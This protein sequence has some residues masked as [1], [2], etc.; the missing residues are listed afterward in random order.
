MKVLDVYAVY[1]PGCHCAFTDI[2]YRHERVYLAFREAVNHGVSASGQI[3]VLSSADRGRTF[4][5]HARIAAAG[6]DLRDPHFFTVDGRVGLMIPSWKVDSA[7]GGP[8]RTCHVAFST[9][10]LSWELPELS[11]LEG[12]TLWRPAAGPDGMVYAVGYTAGSAKGDY[13]AVLHRTR[14]G[15]TWEEVSVVHDEDGANETDIVFLADGEIVALVRCERN[16]CFPL[17][18]RSRPPYTEWRK[19]R[20]DRFLQGPLLVRDRKGGL[21]AVGRSAEPMDG[22]GKGTCMTRGF[23]LDPDTGKTAYLFT[24][25]SGG[26]TSYAGYAEIGEGTALLSYYSGHGYENGTYR[27][28]LEVQRTAVYVARLAVSED[29]RETGDADRKADKDAV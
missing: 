27:S 20:C 10:M 6:Y 23:S 11:E 24:L 26:D 22:G 15:T 7:G 12:W 25:P 2:L 16:P 28:G 8:V 19:V 14:N 17:V 5:P 1:D 18:A 21:V 9:D 4:Q 3:V 13:R 29:E